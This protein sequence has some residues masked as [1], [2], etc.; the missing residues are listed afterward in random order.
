[1]RLFIFEPYNWVYYGGAIGVIA[2]SYNE[3]INML[4]ADKD[5]NFKERYFGKNKKDF[6]ESRYDQCQWLLTHTIKVVNTKKGILFK[7]WNYV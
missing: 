4:L 1:M 5:E 3:A 2:E 6:K 7:N